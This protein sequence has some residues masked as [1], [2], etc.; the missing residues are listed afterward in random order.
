MNG[1]ALQR[2]D[3]REAHR[4]M[5]DSPRRDMELSDIDSDSLHGLLLLFMRADTAKNGSL[6]L[7]EFDDLSNIVVSSSCVT[8]LHDVNWSEM[9]QEQRSRLLQTDSHGHVGPQEWIRFY[10][11]MASKTTRGGDTRSSADRLKAQVA[12]CQD[13]LEAFPDLEV[14]TRFF[15]SRVVFSFSLTC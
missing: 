4:R 15:R 11:R 6:Q 1:T 13:M 14:C 3:C 8:Q 7:Q 2:T 12:R 10:C 9:T 5:D